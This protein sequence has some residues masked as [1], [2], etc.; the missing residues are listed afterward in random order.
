MEFGEKLDTL[1]K[2]LNKNGTEYTAKSEP[3]ESRLIGARP[4]NEGEYHT[5][6]R[7][8]IFKDLKGEMGLQ[9]GGSV[10]RDAISKAEVKDNAFVKNKEFSP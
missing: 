4:A 7:E 5:H 8:K 10:L 9:Q 1:D 3:I 2:E 6:D